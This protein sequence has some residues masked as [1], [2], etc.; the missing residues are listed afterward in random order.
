MCRPHSLTTFA[1][2]GGIIL[3]MNAKRQTGT[4]IIPFGALPEK[5]EL[6]TATVFTGTGVDVEFIVPNRTR[7]TKT[8]DI[9]MDGLDWEIKVPKGSSSRT[10]ENNF[11]AAVKQSVN[12][13]F[14][15]RRTPLP[16]EKCIAQLKKEF[17]PRKR[18][19]QLRVITKHEQILT[20]GK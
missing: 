2:W 18:I 11:R 15:L 4:I 1:S 17:E 19:K 12:V 20:F 13:I 3:P 16:D 6:E 8:P 5:H 10:I 9:R 14:D 7:G